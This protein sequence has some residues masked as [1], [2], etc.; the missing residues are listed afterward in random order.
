M[1]VTPRPAR[2][3]SGIPDRLWVTATAKTPL[4]L[5]LVGLGLLIVVMPHEISGDG[6]VRFEGVGDL[7]EHGHLSRMKYSLVGSLFS[8]PLYCLGKLLLTPSWWCARFNSFI[9]AAGILIA[10]WLLRQQTKGTYLQKF[11][12]LLIAAS[13]FSYHLRTN[14]G[15]VFTAVFVAVGIIALRFGHPW[16]GYSAIILGVVNTPAAIAGLALV[17]MKQALEMRK[18]RQLVPLALAGVLILLEAWLRKGGPLTSG[19]EGD[20]GFLTIMPY[21]GGPG[22]SYPFF[23]GLLGILLSFGK[24]LVFFAP[25]LLLLMRKRDSIMDMRLHES[26]MLWMWFLV[27]LVLIYAKWWAWY[28]GWYWGPRFFLFASVPASLAI[29]VRLQHPQQLSQNAL[30]AVA[31]ILTLSA[32]VGMDGALFGQNDLEICTQNNYAQEYLCWYVPEFSV[33]WHPFFAGF[34][35]RIVSAEGLVGV[36]CLVVYVWLAVPV[37]AEILKRWSRVTAT[38]RP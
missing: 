26:Y 15:E 7:I 30:F 23:L 12:L 1:H 25:G 36:Y 4:F 19:Y 5:I 24:G 21:S 33:L 8:V 38:S 31:L 14:Y 10:Y 9:F 37:V 11:L 22:F 27:G 20:R 16:K 29:A 6:L 17:T 35:V 2:S 3:S 28:G 13:M 34:P 32:W 18:W